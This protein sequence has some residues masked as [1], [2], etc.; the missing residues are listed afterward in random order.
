MVA[1]ILLPGPEPLVGRP[2]RGAAPLVGV[3]DRTV[4]L[5]EGPCFCL[6]SGGG[7]LVPGGAQGLFFHDA[8]LL[9]ELTLAV[10]GRAPELLDVVRASPAAVTF[11]SRCPPRDGAAEST[12]LVERRRRVGSGMR[13]E[14]AIRNV[15]P[16]AS[17]CQLELRVGTDLADVDAVRTGAAAGL[18]PVAAEAAAGGVRFTVRRHGVRVV[19]PEA[20]ATSPNALR[21][22]A[23][24]P[25]GGSWRATVDVIAI[26][27]GEEIEP[28]GGWDD[29]VDAAAERLAR[30][31]SSMP[32][33]ETD[34]RQLRAA[35]AQ[36]ADDL[37]MLR[38]EDP[39]VPE[40]VVIAA[41]APWSMRL[42]GRDALLTAWMA[43]LVDPDVGL[44]ALE[45]LARF[46]G[47]KVDP[48]T[49][50]EPGRI[51]HSLGFSGG[52]GLGFG[53]GLSY[54][55]VD[56]T[57]LFV[58]L[59]GE[60]RRWG[61]APE[62]VERL[63]PH[64]DRAL[65]WVVDHGD[66]DGDGYV[67]YQRP[68]DRGRLHQGWRDAPGSIRF[69]DGTHAQGPIALAEVQGYVYAAFVARA[70]FAREAG[71]TTASA[72]WRGRADALRER[73][74][75]D[76]WLDGE[77]YVAMGLD[78]EKQQIDGIGSSAGHCLWTGILDEDK[79]ALVAQ[80]L[81][82]PELFSG[83]GVRTLATTNVGYNPLSYQVGSVWPHD[84]AIIAAGLM[85]YGFVSEAQRVIGGMLDAAAAFDGRLPE[86]FAGFDR[87]EF[88]FPV[89]YPSS[90]SPQAWAAAAPLS[91][92]RTLLRLEP[93]V[94]AGRVRL[95]PALL[96]SLGRLRVEGVPLLGARCTVEVDGD[97]TKVSG[98][99]G[100]ID[101]VLEPRSALGG[102][103]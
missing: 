89:S 101:L 11:V 68:T 69:A 93:W 78:R 56:S 33:I 7:D 3:D 44:G 58:M 39:D 59:L 84:N 53:G 79:A 87:G 14:I 99:P 85:R 66:R 82:S 67:E 8:R 9:S 37:G 19:A 75:R 100:E 16:E 20:V 64:A 63:L 51:P 18:P 34:D 31:R 83:W 70:H 28:S 71:D 65:E 10:D 35:L 41:G 30:W 26:L 102:H 96:P 73:F 27:E 4:T 29:D 54:G 86:L 61:L 12:M 55:A 22:E 60:L 77:G 46:Q 95:A 45:T 97:E 103:G 42:H 52:P 43:L 15:G 21:F 80:R 57:P 24:V 38:V 17:Y 50:E 40:R 72:S 47:A 92:L 25:A 48:R 32:M 76:F 74:N 98:L 2:L 5:L 1:E 36:S 6:S 91:F 81:L 94:P 88:E 13:E 23:I 62:P 49:E 90:C